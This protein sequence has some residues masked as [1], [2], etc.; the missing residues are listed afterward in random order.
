VPGDSSMLLAI[1]TSTEMSGVA[2][3]DGPVVSELTWRAGRNQTVGLLKQIEHLLEINQ[4]ELSDLGAVAIA[5]GP[6]TFNG[7]RVGLS[8]AKGLGYGMDIPIIGVSTLEVVAYPFRGLS[9]TIRAFVPAGRGRAVYADFAYRNGRWV[10]S[11][12]MQNA[13]FNELTI[14]VAERT[15]LAGE[16]PAGVELSIPAEAK[17]DLP[18]P[19]MR[20]RRP[21]Y[22]AEIAHSRWCAGDID[23]LAALE[24]VYVHGNR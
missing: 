19:A 13:P 9:R 21:A 24:P 11:G 8:T 10:R 15:L 17:L 20:A 7:L 4:R 3:Y 12:E 2:L 1:D 5:V 6:G 14:G 22:L 16:V 18:P 23:E